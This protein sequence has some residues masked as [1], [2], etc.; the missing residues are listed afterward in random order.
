M[1]P[2][3][4]GRHDHDDDDDDDDVSCRSRC[5]YS[6]SQMQ[7]IPTHLAAF[8]P[9]ANDYNSVPIPTA[10]EIGMLLCPW[11]PDLTRSHIALDLLPTTHEA[12]Q[13]ASGSILRT[14]HV[15]IHVDGSGGGKCVDGTTGPAAWSFNVVEVRPHEKAYVRWAGGLVVTDPAARG[16]IGADRGTNATA[17]LSA[18]CFATLWALQQPYSSVRIVYDAEHAA[19]MSQGIWDPSVNID[20]IQTNSELIHLA[21]KMFT[22]S[23]THV[24]SHRGDPWN[25]LADAGAT[26]YSVGRIRSELAF[27]SIIADPKLK[28]LLPWAFLH[29]L[30]PAE[31]SQYPPC[32][33]QGRLKASDTHLEPLIGL[34]PHVLA[35]RIDAKASSPAVDNVS[36]RRPHMVIFSRLPRGIRSQ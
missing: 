2:K 31:R 34:P 3:R 5:E 11:F 18:M 12:L 30:Q 32:I 10:A 23:W 16:F 19:A 33:S 13:Q 15:D 21:S 1:P 28:V 14:G 7:P 25:E 8:V 22:L 17:E 26:G 20:I 24:Y 4:E 27:P 35:Q 29:V 6:T 9:H 36:S